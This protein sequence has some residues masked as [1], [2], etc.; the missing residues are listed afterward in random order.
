MNLDEL[1]KAMLN[2]HPNE[3]KIMMES[4]FQMI[5]EVD[6]LDEFKEEFY[7]MIEFVTEGGEGGIVPEPPRSHLRRIK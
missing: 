4:V 2:L 6:D 5:L 7:D 1:K 3:H